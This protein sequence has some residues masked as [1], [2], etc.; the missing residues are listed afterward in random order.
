MFM[1]FLW[2]FY[3]YG[4][5]IKDGRQP[6]APVPKSNFPA[7]FIKVRIFKSISPLHLGTFSN[8]YGWGQN[9]HFTEETHT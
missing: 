2:V 5:K 1:L 3:E 4:S 9:K 7:F 6:G 8:D